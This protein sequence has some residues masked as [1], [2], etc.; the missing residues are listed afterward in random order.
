MQLNLSP[1]RLLLFSFRHSEAKPG[2]DELQKALLSQRDEL[3]KASLS[4]LDELPKALLPQMD[5]LPKSSLLDLV[6][7]PEAMLHHTEVKPDGDTTGLGLGRSCQHS[8]P[9]SLVRTWPSSSLTTTPTS[10]RPRRGYD[11]LSKKGY[12]DLS[13]TEAVDEHAISAV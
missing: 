11:S 2:L 13:L 4:Q 10:W 1:T 6:E 12:K 8:G 9:S 3:P 7:L 5:K